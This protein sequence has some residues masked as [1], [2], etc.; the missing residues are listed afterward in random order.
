MANVD[1]PCGLKPVRYLNGSPWNGKVTMYYKTAASNA[2]YKGTPV[3]HG[4]TTA[5]DGITPTCDILA[6]SGK[7][8]MVGVAV[9]FSNSRYLA[10]DV[11]DLSRAYCPASTAMYV[12]VVD[13]ANV[14]FEIQ[15]DNAVPDWIEAADVGQYFSIASHSGGSTSTGLSSAELDSGGNTGTEAS[16]A[17]QLMG[18]VDRV[19][20]VMGSSAYYAKWLVRMGTHA[21]NVVAV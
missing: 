19:D 6:S 8:G 17:V 11:T 16:G 4:G 14:L 1:K 3:I 15:E 12:A 10:A 18:L 7:G 20:N 5:T 21:Y 13:D 2:I 9:G